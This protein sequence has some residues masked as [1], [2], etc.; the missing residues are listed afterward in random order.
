M[1]EASNASSDSDTDNN[2]TGND[3]IF[4]DILTKL[5]SLKVQSQKEEFRKSSLKEGATYLK[6]FINLMEKHSKDD[7]IVKH[8]LTAETGSS[9]IIDSL[10]DVRMGKLFESDS[11]Y[12]YDIFCLYIDLCMLSGIKYFLKRIDMDHSIQ[13][14]YKQCVAIILHIIVLA[15]SYTKFTINDL[16]QPLDNHESLLLMLNYIKDDLEINSEATYSNTTDSIL[17]FLWNYA[18]KTIIVPNLIKA[19]YPKA[20]L[21]WLSIVCK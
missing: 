17:S 18:D 6:E 4:S 19:G 11:D 21:N 20:V 13:L 3:G 7:M 10:N 12:A 1:S 15:V 2:P 14:F 8:C 5:A 16:Q 9:L